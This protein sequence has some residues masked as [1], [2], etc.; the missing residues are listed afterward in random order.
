M[1]FFVWDPSLDTGI[2]V[3]DNQH[4]RIVDYINDLHAAINDR[5]RNTVSDILDQLIDYTVT[6]FSFEE[7]LMEQ[8]S[9]KLTDAHKNT[10]RAFT[11]R[12]RTYADRFNAGEDISRKLLSDLR[13]WLMNHIKQEDNDYISVVKPMVNK[14]GKGWLAKRLSRFFG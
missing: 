6:H 14:S 7:S 13:I 9:Y 11:S 10:H 12:I 1:S 2:E 4:R 8:A 5:D 3:I